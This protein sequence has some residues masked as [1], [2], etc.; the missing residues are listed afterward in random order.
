[1]PQVDEAGP[2]DL[3]RRDTVGGRERVGQPAGQLARVGADLLAQLQRHVGG[4]IAVLGIARPLDGDRRGQRGGVEAVLGQHRSSGGAEQL[5]QV[6]GGHEGPSYGL[7]PCPARIHSGRPGGRVDAL[8]LGAEPNGAASRCAPVAQGIERLPPEQKAAGS[9][10]AGGTH[11][12]GVS[13]NIHSPQAPK[14]ACVSRRCHNRA[15]TLPGIDQ[16]V[17]LAVLL[18]T[19]TIQVTDFKP[20]V[21]CHAAGLMCPRASLHGREKATSTKDPLLGLYRLGDF[22]PVVGHQLLFA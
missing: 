10:P 5:G 8:S 16:R 6:G 11:L 1:M 9:N 22:G 12:P 7:G 17:V 15:Q 3:G 21:E 13:P 14:P 19:C 4:V 20:V 18:D 2:R